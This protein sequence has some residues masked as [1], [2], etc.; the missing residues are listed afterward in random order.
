MPVPAI[1]HEVAL[2]V[3]STLDELGLRSYVKTSG[4][5]GLHIYVPV[6]EKTFTHAQVRLFAAA[7][8][9]AVAD[10]ARTSPRSSG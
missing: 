6:I 9:K 7:I 2:L 10:N 4:A 5:S 3:K 1:E 8:A